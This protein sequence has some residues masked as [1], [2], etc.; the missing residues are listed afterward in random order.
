VYVREIGIDPTYLTNRNNLIDFTYNTYNRKY[1][2]SGSPTPPWM[3]DDIEALLIRINDNGGPWFDY[4]EP[5]DYKS[6]VKSKRWAELVIPFLRLLKVNKDGSLSKR[7]R[8]SVAA[9]IKDHENMNFTS[10]D[11]KD[12][13]D[14][15]YEDLAKVRAGEI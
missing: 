1:F 14:N 8:P 3:T 6:V 4:N 5:L 2:E 9:L 7:Q 15:F 11:R 10:G 12:L 13:F